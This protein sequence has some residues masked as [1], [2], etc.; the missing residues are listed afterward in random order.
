MLYAQSKEVDYK[1]EN[2]KLVFYRNEKIQLTK[3]ILYRFG[4]QT[5]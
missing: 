2:N 1:S 3:R 4:T 5:Q